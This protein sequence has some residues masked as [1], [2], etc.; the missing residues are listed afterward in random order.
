MYQ[1]TVFKNISTTV[2]VPKG[3]AGSHD[4]A[5][6]YAL[7]AIASKAGNLQTIEQGT[8]INVNEIPDEPAK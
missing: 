2:K 6:A 7:K 3:S 4:E 5:V 1:V 8:N